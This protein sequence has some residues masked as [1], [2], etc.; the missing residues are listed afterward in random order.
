MNINQEDS[1]INPFFTFDSFDCEGISELL[2]VL[3]STEE[4]FTQFLKDNRDIVKRISDQGIENPT[5][6]TDITWD[7]ANLIFIASQSLE[8]KMHPPFGNGKPKERLGRIPTSEGNPLSYLLMYLITP[9][10]PDGDNM[11]KLLSQLH[12]GFSKSVHG[13]ERFS[14]GAWGMSLQGYLLSEEVGSLHT[15]LKK[16]KWT[17]SANEPL[18]G[19]VRTFANDLSIILRD[20]KKQ[21]IGVLMRSHH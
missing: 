3:D 15:F 11:L 14:R 5:T 6:R 19:G 18:D 2:T 17:I 10:S 13:H 20:A 7:D 1:G 8:S 4:D 12:S 9:K 16:L 21:K